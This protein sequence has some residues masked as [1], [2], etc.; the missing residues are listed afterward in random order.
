M[1]IFCDKITAS[2]E[3]HVYVD[4]STTPY[5]TAFTKIKIYSSS[6]SWSEIE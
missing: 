4:I 2:K 5:K 1:K 6:E 3:Q